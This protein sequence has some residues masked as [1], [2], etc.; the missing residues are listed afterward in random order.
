MTTRI[1]TT[2]KIISISLLVC[3][4]VFGLSACSS[5]KDKANSYYENGMKLFEDNEFAKANIEFRNALQIDRSMTKAI[6]AQALVAEKQSKHLQSFKLLNAV[7]LNDPKHIEALVKVGRLLLVAGKIDKALEKS[8]AALKVA[9]D[10]LSV[11]AFRAAVLFKL[12]DP[13]GAVKIAKQVIAKDPNYV[14]ALIVLAIERLA[15]KDSEKAIEYLD[16][17][18]KNN[19]KNIVLQLIKVQALNNLAKLD[20]AEDVFKRLIN[21]YPD[22]PAFNYA[23]AEF[24]FQHDRKD[25]AVKEFWTVVKNNPDEL[26]AKIKLVQLL[27]FVN[28]PNAAQAQLVEFVTQDPDNYELKFALVQFYISNK[29]L[30]QANESITSIISTTTD[31]DIIL[32]A[33][34]I[35]ASLLLAKGD[36][37]AA[38]KV[39]NDILSTDER[40]ENALILKSSIDI[41]RQQY[42]TAISD[43]RVVLRDTPN[44]SRALFFLAKAHYLSGSPEL[45]DEQYLKAFKTSQFNDTYGLAYAQFLLRRNQPDRAEKILQNVL[46]VSPKNIAA[47]QLLAQTRLKLGNW[48]GAQQVADDIKLIGDKNNT[49]DQITNAILVGKKEY[50]ESISLLKKTYDSAPGNIQPVVALVRTYLLAGKP[51]EADAFLNAVINASPNNFNARI[52]RGQVYLSQGKIDEA[53]AIY[54][55]VVKLAPENS[56]GHYNLALAYI[57]TNKLNEA[58]TSLKDGLT[59]SPDNFLLRLTMASIYE[60]LGDFDNAI[61]VYQGLIKDRPGA[62]IIANNLASLLAEHRTDKASLDQAYTLSKRFNRTEI[63]QFKDTFGWASYRVGKYSDA[64]PLLEGAAE[65]LPQLPIVQYHLGMNYLAQDDKTQARAALEKALELAGDTPF[66]QADEIRAALE[67]L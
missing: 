41:D 12:D 26:S 61:N 51:D 21:Y 42:D 1:P 2:F 60:Q 64:V 67:K 22:T 16:Q 36:K 9:P 4:S 11:L 53:V 56:V 24:Y 43:L 59:V 48:I 54:Q 7:L 19:T 66:Q 10:D 20:L 18:L 31:A 52:L 13:Q 3:L 63:P 40:N 45:A 65:G 39:V 15:A 27:N 29:N 34:G 49:A 57:R 55:E 14:D 6:Y 30:T 62:D 46:S 8:D 25:D 23:L 32:K 47:M 28:G 5:P 50:N 58:I 35:K 17:G 38:E 44:S 33:K 37:D